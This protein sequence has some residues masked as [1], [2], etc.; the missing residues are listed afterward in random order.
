MAS[1]GMGKPRGISAER[2][3]AQSVAG[4]LDTLLYMDQP[5]RCLKNLF[6]VRRR[7]EVI[8]QDRSGDKTGRSKQ[9]I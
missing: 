1:G 3:V 6:Q 2:D 8:R 7:C 9:G 4:T 5:G